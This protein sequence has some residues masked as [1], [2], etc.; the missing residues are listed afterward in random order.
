MVP[1]AEKKL[2]CCGNRW[3]WSFSIF[4]LA[5]PSFSNTLVTTTVDQRW[6]REK[7]K[8]AAAPI[9]NCLWST[10]IGRKG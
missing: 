10:T 3:V 6:V 2:H 7:G 1:P 5:N 8:M 4:K 9:G